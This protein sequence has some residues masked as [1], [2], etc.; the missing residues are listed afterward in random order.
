[1]RIWFG[2]STE[3]GS[4]EI[5]LYNVSSCIR[6]TPDEE[7]GVSILDVWEPLKPYVSLFAVASLSRYT[8][9][10]SESITEKLITEMVFEPRTNLQALSS[11]QKTG[12]KNSGSSTK[13][14]K[15][16]LRLQNI[17]KTCKQQ[18]KSSSCKGN[19]LI[20]DMEDIRSTNFER[21]VN[22]V[23]GTAS[24][25]TT[26][27]PSKKISFYRHAVERYLQTCVKLIKSLGICCHCCYPF[28]IYPKL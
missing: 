21:I 16:N 23:K 19:W 8:D 2:F 10:L 28:L 25:V 3:P 14:R 7:Q 9:C 1:M 15:L 11:K 24:T 27:V 20:H 13:L 12:F 5:S 26:L 18:I 17:A 4:Y 22:C 6:T